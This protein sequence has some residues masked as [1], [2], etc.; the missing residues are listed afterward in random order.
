MSKIVARYRGALLGQ[1]CRL[2]RV[3]DARKKK[4]VSLLLYV[5]TPS[6]MIL[7]MCIPWYDT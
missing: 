3:S 1:T 2:S 4:E 7:S 5:L 6:M